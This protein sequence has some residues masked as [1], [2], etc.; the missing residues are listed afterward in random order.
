VG[1]K[2]TVI[3][4][5]QHLVNQMLQQNAETLLSLSGHAHRASV[6]ASRSVRVLEWVRDKH[7][8]K[9]VASADSSRSGV[10]SAA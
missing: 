9:R 2:R 3:D 7:R 10:R 4:P 1:S 8:A 5:E 6:A